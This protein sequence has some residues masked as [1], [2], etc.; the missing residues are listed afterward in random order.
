MRAA[1]VLIEVEPG[2][3]EAV[4]NALIEI[5]P[6]HEVYSISGE[7]DILA[8]LVVNSMD[9]VPDVITARIQR[10]PGLRRSHTLFAFSAFK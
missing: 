3:V 5:E 9:E 6:V 7:Y 8:K 4:A 10:I 2:R 1:F